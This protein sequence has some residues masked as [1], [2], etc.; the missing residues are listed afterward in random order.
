MAGKNDV[1]A[2]LAELDKKLSQASFGGEGVQLPEIRDALSE[3][4]AAHEKQVKD[5]GAKLAQVTAK[6]DSAVSEKDDLEKK[7]S[8]FKEKIADREARLE[9]LKGV[10]EERDAL[11]AKLQKIEDANGGVILDGELHSIYR[12]ETALEM[13]DSWRKRYIHDNDITLVVRKA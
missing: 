11:K 6:L 3:L 8:F 7:I 4:K 5:I 12:R 13:V 9:I 1:D 2:K 10:P